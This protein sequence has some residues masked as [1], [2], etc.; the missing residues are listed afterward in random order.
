[1]RLSSRLSQTEGMKS[2]RGELDRE[3]HAVELRADARDG[4]RVAVIQM[5]V[6]IDR[7]GPLDEQRHGV[8][9]QRLGETWPGR[10]GQR[11]RRDVDDDLA[12]HA[13]CLPAGRED[14]N[15]RSGAE[16]IGGEEGGRREDVLA[17]VE[18]EEA[19]LPGEIVG[20][21]RHRKGPRAVL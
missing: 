14:A 15:A 11:Q 1:M 4:G 6:A 9:K 8:G 21:A 3:G 20:Q 18:D 5:E 7:P 16:D 17:V 12:S 19:A 13:E 10:V 2:H